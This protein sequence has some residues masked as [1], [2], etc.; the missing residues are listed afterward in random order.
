MINYPTSLDNFSNPTTSDPLKGGTVPH[1]TQHSDAND[2]IEAL[3]AKVGVDN[4]AVT[5]SHDYKLSEVTG[6]DKAVGKTATQTLSNKTLTAPQINMGSDATGDMYFRNSS[7]ATSRLPIGATG[8]ILEAQS[9]GVPA[10]V[11]NPSAADASTTVKGVSQEATQAQVLAR[12]ATGSTSARLFVNPSTLT[13]VQTYDY[14]ADAGGTD[15]YAITVTPAPTAYVTGQVFRFRANTANT[16]TATLNVNSL[17][18]I[19]IRKPSPSGYVDLETGDILAQQLV[20]V[21]YNGTH[22]IATSTLSSN[23]QRITAGVVSEVSGIFTTQ[24]TDRTVSIGFQPR[25]LMVTYY[26]QGVRNL[27]GDQHVVQGTAIF[28]GTTLISNNVL[29]FSFDTNG[30]NLTG[31]SNTYGSMGNDPSSTSAIEAG[32]ANSNNSIQMTL[33][34]N[35]V[36][37]TGFVMRFQTQANNGTATIQARGKASYIAFS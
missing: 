7:G 25:L 2:A 13:T 18:A 20:E 37:S 27:G 24:T 23:P 12:T 19:T 28:S 14:V 30:D 9:S 11:P 16:G 6:S 4:S 32:E 36:S 3:Q 35:S 31:F 10:W 33:T 21:M 22:M 17:G 5:S 1:E 34:I 29:G 15:A 26:I 8:T